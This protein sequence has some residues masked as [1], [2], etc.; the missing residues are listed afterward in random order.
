MKAFQMQKLLLAALLL[1]SSTVWAH[2]SSHP[3][4]P[5]QSYQSGVVTPELAT[6]GWKTD[7]YTYTSDLK[8]L[9]C[10]AHESYFFYRTQKEDK[11]VCGGAANN[12]WQEVHKYAPPGMEYAGFQFL[13]KYYIILYY[14]KAEVIATQAQPL[15]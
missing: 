15:K 11:W 8:M 3:A 14:R 1:I 5:P 10:P 4:K 2:G 7:H 13:D 6:V 9:V 12:R